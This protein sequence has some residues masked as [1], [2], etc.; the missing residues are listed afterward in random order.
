[1]VS[2]DVGVPAARALLD[3]LS[4][5]CKREGKADADS[6]AL[7]L[8]ELV[9]ERLRKAAPPL[10][11]PRPVVILLVGVNGAGKTTTAGKLS[12]YLSAQGRKVLLAAGDTFRAAAEEQ[13]TE[14]AMRAKW[15]YSGRPHGA[16]PAAVVFDAL[17]TGLQH[18][19]THWW[20]IP[21]D[22]ST[23]GRT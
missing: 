4:E 10:E 23:T 15:N 11:L 14:W 20:W 16:A 18:G 17:K 8:R 1:L 7:F 9:A 3:G 6:A 19:A 13:L 22:A 12:S 21:R 5:R 2:A